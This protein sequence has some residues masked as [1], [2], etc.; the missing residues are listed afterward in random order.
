MKALSIRQP[1][2]WAILHAGKR[3]ENRDWQGCHYRGP[4]LIHASKFGDALREREEALEDARYAV[5]I[6]RKTGFLSSDPITFGTVMA[7]R[8]GIVGICDVVAVHD[9]GIM[10]G[11]RM[12][13]KEPGAV[14]VG[15]G[16]K[17]PTVEELLRF[18]PPWTDYPLGLKQPMLPLDAKT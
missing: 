17:R 9:H 18:D 8:G 12:T 15:C 1:W 7:N 14:C 16:W 6:G 11:H 2:A 13:S 3:V 4:L 10:S 5:T